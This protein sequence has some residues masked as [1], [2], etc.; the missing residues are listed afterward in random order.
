M[1]G[2][3]RIGTAEDVVHCVVAGLDLLALFGMLQVMNDG[4]VPLGR[5]EFVFNIGVLIRP[6]RHL[7]W[8]THKIIWHSKRLPVLSLRV[9]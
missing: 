1:L 8:M 3:V 5:L 4:L 6:E 9:S 2:L 7:Y